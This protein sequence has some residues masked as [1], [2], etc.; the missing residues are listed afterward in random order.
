MHCS[1][2][3]PPEL[4]AI[5]ACIVLEEQT[6]LESVIFFFCFPVFNPKALI[7]KIDQLK[8]NKTFAGPTLHHYKP[9]Q[10]SPSS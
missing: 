5:T 8:R 2:A 9:C 7:L 6:H 10:V 3:G 4:V 1:C